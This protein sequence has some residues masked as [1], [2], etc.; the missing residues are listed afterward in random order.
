MVARPGTY[1]ASNNAG[2]LAPEEYG[3]TDLKQFYAGLALA[4]NVEPVPQGGSRL[5]MRSRHLGR[6]RRRTEAVSILSFAPPAGT[7]NAP[8]VISTAGFAQAAISVVAF[9][10]LIATQALGAIMQVEYLGTDAGWRSFGAP[11]PINT[12]GGT[13]TIS[14][15]PGASVV[16]TGIRLSLA[17]APPSATTFS[18]DGVFVHRQTSDV[19]AGARVKPFT[20]SLTQTYVAVF[21]PGLVDFY[22]DGVFVGSSLSPIDTAQLAAMDLQQRLDTMLL[23]HTDI[24]SARIV[25]DGADN[26]WMLS[27][28]PNQN[29]PNVDLGAVYNNQVVDSWALI[30]RFS[31]A[32]DDPNRFGAGLS[33]TLSVN[34]EDAI[35]GFPGG[36]P[37]WATI[38]GL[39]KT[40]IEATSSVEPGIAV[41]PTDGGS[42]S[43]TISIQFTGAGNIGK[44]NTLSAQIVNTAT[45]AATVAHTAVGDP[46][47]EALMSNGRG[48]AA[49]AA[50]YQDRLVSGGFKA[51]R[52]AFLAS[53]TGEY[54]DL[55][56]KLQAPSGAI[57]ANLDTDGAEQ[58]QRIVNDTYLLFFTSD[59]EYF[60]SDRAIDRT[61]PPNVVNS[62]RYGSASDLPIVRNEGEII[63]AS[64]NKSVLYAATY[65]QV[66]TKYVATPISLL[67][68]HI[69]NNMI[70][71]ALQRPSGVTNAARLWMPRI[72]GSMTVG[73]MLR[74]QDAT[75]FVRWQTPGQVTSACVDG[76]NVP[77]LLVSRMVGVDTE[78][79]IERLEDGLIFDD[80]VEQT[81][82]EAQT[83]IGGLGVHEGADV[84]ADADGYVIGPFTVASGAITIP[85]PASNVKV[86]RW[87]A[88]WARTLPLPSEVA[89]RIVL[90]RPKRVHTVRLDLVDTTSV[91]VGANDQPALNVALALVGDPI[92]Q[93]QKPVNRT[94]E[95]TGLV[96][97]TETGQVDITQTRPGRLAWRGITIEART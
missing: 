73:I 64:R 46:G 14:L 26:R 8:A 60:I 36:T 55:N 96:G 59:A 72:D 92:D 68:P 97:F 74:N 61:K 2:E 56:T 82:G 22:R 29:V 62:S 40:A 63:W 86:G 80:V 1:Q 43:Q 15:S 17:S 76:K 16:A 44:V 42:G 91:A 11:F 94:A 24:V 18:G 38:S 58:L 83:V 37:N 10:N 70:D 77:H 87:T 53:V 9:R 84:W 67:A 93:A 49:C 90:R 27:S 69:V 75:A 4:R 65:D 57:L 71:M 23:H 51:K 78:L 88:P 3:R 7:F 95:I 85:T 81:F 6:V 47:G 52:G 19:A 54:F 35:V 25:R 12:T 21:L 20:Y 32:E 79:H 30:L 45:A 41:T 5:S 28:I 33:L 13:V 34:G 89:E 50:F 48:Y 66:S 31:T 39:I